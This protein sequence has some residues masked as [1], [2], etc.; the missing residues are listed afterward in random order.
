MSKSY[1]KASFAPR[2]I[3]LSVLRFLLIFTLAALLGALVANESPSANIYFDEFTSKWSSIKHIG[4]VR[5]LFS[6]IIDYSLIFIIAS[7]SAL[8]FFCPLVLQA[9]ASICG[10][11]C[12]VRIG[13][14][15]LCCEYTS[16]HKLILLMILSASLFEIILS[17]WSSCFIS[18]NTQCVLAARNSHNKRK[19]YVSPII[20]KWMLT[21]ISLLLST[22]IL[23]V[24]D[25]MLVCS[26]P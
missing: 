18:I 16:R 11:V 1:E 24:I 5:F 9:L 12:G 3:T 4:F 25:Y 21:S 6:S 23:S 22:P 8:T 20:K 14:I 17:V 10:V 7:V 13:V 19:I 26:S 2:S 15:F